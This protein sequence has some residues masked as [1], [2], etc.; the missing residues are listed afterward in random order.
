MHNRAYSHAYPLRSN[1]SGKINRHASKSGNNGA[2]NAD[3]F[4]RN[5]HN[6]RSIDSGIDSADSVYGPH[7]EPAQYPTPTHSFASVPPAVPAFPMYGLL[8][9]QRRGFTYIRLLLSNMGLLSKLVSPPKPMG[10]NQPVIQVHSAQQINA[11]SVRRAL[12]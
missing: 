9:H 6:D 12:C 8:K 11:E 1:G 5:N 2:N 3:Q 4:N 10:R 7:H